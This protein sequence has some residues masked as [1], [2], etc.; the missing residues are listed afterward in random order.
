MQISTDLG[1]WIAAIATI[2]ILS[3]AFKDNPLYRLVENVYVGVSAGHAL[4]LGW[5]N[6]R[7]QGIG[8]LIDD[9]DWSLLVP[10]ALGILLYTRFFK[11]ISWLSRFPLAMLVGIGTGLAIRGTIGSQIVNQIKSTILPLNSINNAIIIFGTLGVLIYFFFSR[12]HTGPLKHVST[13]GRCIMMVSFGAAFGSTVMG[14]M[15]L[16]INRLHFLYANWLGIIR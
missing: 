13:F 2:G 11:K 12:E 9:G 8:P 10:I 7:D 6:I 1:V 15:A 16:L 5:I 14:R 4:V 3:F